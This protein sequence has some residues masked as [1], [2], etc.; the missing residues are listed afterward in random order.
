M[1]IILIISSLQGGGAERVIVNLGNYWVDSGF[2]VVLVTMDNPKNKEAYNLRREVKRRNIFY[3]PRHY[4]I[5][6]LFNYFS[7]I[8]RLRALIKIENPDSVISFMTPTNIMTIIA[9]LGLGKHC[10]V[11]ERTN[12]IMFSYGLINDLL[13]RLLYRFSDE[14]VVQTNP[15]A[16]WLSVCTNANISVIPNFIRDKDIVGNGNGKKERIVISVGRLVKE[17][18]FDVLIRSY[19]KLSPMFPGWRLII[20]GEGPEYQNLQILITENNLD[21]KVHLLGWVKD[22]FLFL[23]IASIAVHPS[24][25]EGFP[26]ALLEAMACGLPCI[27][28]YEAGDML[29]KPEIDGILVPFG[30]AEKLEDALIRLIVNPNLR[31]RLGKNALQVRERYSQDLVMKLWNAVSIRH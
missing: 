20:L 8:Y 30:D 26:N 19:A 29:I 3:Y 18:G 28:S 24:S 22:P 7:Q 13:R 11:S 2:E 12:S 16:K 6:K 25:I 17:K 1:K 21:Q 31:D 4:L 15:I 5:L 10:V 14:V 9:C 27:A 23:N